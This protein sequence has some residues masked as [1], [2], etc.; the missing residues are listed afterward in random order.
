MITPNLFNTILI[1]PF[2][3]ILLALYHLFLI[4]K[5]PYAFGFAII[6][7]T[8]LIRLALHPFFHQQFAMARKMQA[9]KPELDKLSQKHKG[10][11]KRLQEEQMKLYK[12]MGVNPASGCLFAII[13]IPI[14][15]ALYQVLSLFF[16]KGGV[17]KMVNEV[18]KIVYFSFLKVS[19]LD[20]MF[21]GINL[22]VS[23]QQFQKYGVYYLAIPVITAILQY[24]QVQTTTP[25]QPKP[26]APSPAQEK[27]ALLKKEEK[28]GDTD[29]AQKMMS[30]Q[31]KFI[32]PLMIG[33]FSYTL[34]VGLSLY[35]NIF[36]IF[37]IVHAKK[38]LD[39]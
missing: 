18:N 29:Y 37:S 17:S 35:W 36:S 2:I 19:S 24:Y 9:M 27:T 3:N 15:I 26:S 8:A 5:I 38:K 30:T 13:Q 39:I 6:G 31:M 28:K 22:G 1:I 11:K 16:L 10:D 33:W 21:F 4:L 25:A 12:Q 7:L 14:F 23:P 20:P 32:F 34:P